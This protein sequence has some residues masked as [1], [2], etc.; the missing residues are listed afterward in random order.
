[1][2]ILA[3]Q[4]SVHELSSR[5]KIYLTGK[6]IYAA[7]AEMEKHFYKKI[8]IITL[9]A[10]E[11]NVVQ[12]AAGR[13]GGVKFRQGSPGFGRGRAGEGPRGAKGSI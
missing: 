9:S 2:C 1:M 6:I 8:Y 5:T 10:G 13:R 4:D 7:L 3:L 12:G 11:G